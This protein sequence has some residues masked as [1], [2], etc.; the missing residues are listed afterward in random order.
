M[1]RSESHGLQIDITEEVV[2]AGYGV[3]GQGEINA[4]QT[5]SRAEGHQP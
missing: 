4:S 5:D 2:F 3:V 1:G